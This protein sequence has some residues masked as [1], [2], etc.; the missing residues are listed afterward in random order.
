MMLPSLRYLAGTAMVVAAPLLAQTTPT[1]TT[2]VQLTSASAPSATPARDSA[3]RRLESFLS[4]YPNS[5]LR[6]EA[7]L[8]LGE[9]LVQE[10][11]ERYAETQRAAARATED[12][13]GRSEATSRPDY[14][15]AL[16]V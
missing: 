1:Q 11:D 15:R 12:T 6:P 7:L 8:Q 5:T 10:A 3:I 14:S 2:P 4:K 9:L 13:T 16:R